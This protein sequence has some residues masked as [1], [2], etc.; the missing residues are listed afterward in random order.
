MMR[1]FGPKEKVIS[2]TSTDGKSDC[3]LT[4]S[5]PNGVK[6]QASIPG[7]RLLSAK[8]RDSQIV[9]DSR[10]ARYED[11]KLSSTEDVDTVLYALYCQ[12]NFEKACFGFQV[13]SGASGD[14]GRIL[15]VVLEATTPSASNWMKFSQ[16]GLRFSEEPPSEIGSQVLLLANTLNRKI[17]VLLDACS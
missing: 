7:F 12:A 2:L 11:R 14:E 10:G 8:Q 6:I 1:L 3:K 17:D 9:V 4:L 16:F 13:S 5:N 15:V